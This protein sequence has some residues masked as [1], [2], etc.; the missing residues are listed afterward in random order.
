MGFYGAVYYLMDTQ[1][2]TEAI[3]TLKEQADIV[4]FVPHWGYETNPKQN[5][6]Q[7]ELAH[8]VIDAG[9]DFVWGSHPHV[10]QEMEVYNGG[11]ICYSLGNFSFGGNVYPEDYDSALIQQEVI[12]G[13]DDSVS[14]GE[15]IVVPVRISTNDTRNNFQPIPYEK[16]TEDYT[17][18][19]EKLALTEK[20]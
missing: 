16:G 18:V 1:V 9:A 7:V 10:L 2:I 11:V 15:T 12:R 3:R 19:L 17:R 13:A 14:L 20:N 8:A 6:E 5:K 4:V